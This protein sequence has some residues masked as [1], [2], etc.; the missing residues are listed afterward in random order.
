MCLTQCVS[1]GCSTVTWT[2]QTTKHGPT[3][4]FLMYASGQTRVFFKNAFLL[5]SLQYPDGPSGGPP[6]KEDL[7]NRHLI[8]QEEPLPSTQ[9]LVAKL[10]VLLLLVAYEDSDPA[11]L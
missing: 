6:N 3:I 11:E 7:T 8:A 9:A 4:L 10:I 5:P 2:S 1:Q